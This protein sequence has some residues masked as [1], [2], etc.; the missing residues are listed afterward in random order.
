MRRRRDNDRARRRDDVRDRLW[1]FERFFERVERLW[2][3]EAP[4][5]IL[6]MPL[7]VGGAYRDAKANS[8]SRLPF[9]VCVPSAG[10]AGDRQDATGV[11]QCP[12]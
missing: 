6:E 10:W 4:P 7:L 9:R 2:R 1:R 5:P 11:R 8:E 3:R 12:P